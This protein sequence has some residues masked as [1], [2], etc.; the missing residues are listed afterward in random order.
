[1]FLFPFADFIILLGTIS[2]FWAVA[3]RIQF[4]TMTRSTI[5]GNWKELVRSVTEGDLEIARYHLDQGVDPNFQHPEAMTTP[6]HEAV[7]AQR[8]DSVKLLLEHPMNPANPTIEADWEGTTPLEEAMI[9]K[10]HD[11]VEI[12][13]RALPES[14]ESESLV[15]WI[16]NNIRTTC[17]HD[18]VTHLLEGG[19]LRAADVQGSER[20]HIT[21]R[22]AGPT[23]SRIHRKQ[24]NLG[25]S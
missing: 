24:Q 9:L 21:G 6:L 20:V 3:V 14:Y 4:E 18:L 16:P 2:I 1:M 11:M 7:K 12:L 8:Y 5:G 25:V 22:I 23:T 13:L 19:A 10:D 15:V 17:Q